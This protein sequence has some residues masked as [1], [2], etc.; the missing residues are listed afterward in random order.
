MPKMGPATPPRAWLA[1]QHKNVHFWCTVMMIIF[2]IMSSKKI[3]GINTRSAI[4]SKDLLQ[5]TIAP[6]IKPACF[7]LL[8]IQALH[9]GCFLSVEL[10]SPEYLDEPDIKAQYAKSYVSAKRVT[11]SVSGQWSHNSGQHKNPG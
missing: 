2:W 1:M 6:Q 3:L 11:S 4:A 5:S 8:Y 10:Y 7:G 9:A